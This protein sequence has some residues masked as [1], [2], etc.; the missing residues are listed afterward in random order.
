MKAKNALRDQCMWR[1][2]ANTDKYDEGRIE[3]KG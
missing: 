1:I 3:D 2:E